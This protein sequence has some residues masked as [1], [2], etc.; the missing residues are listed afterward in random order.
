MKGFPWPDAR[1]W[2]GIGTFLLTMYII[3]LIAFVPELRHDVYFQTL[4]TLIVGTGFINSV[5]PWGYGATKSGGELADKNAGIVADNATANN[6]LA[7]SPVDV[8]VTN[9]PANAIPVREPK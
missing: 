2:I 4:T 6:V 5:V 8:T 9:D 3:T 7:A 1:G